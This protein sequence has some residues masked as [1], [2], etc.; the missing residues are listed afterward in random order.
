M[1]YTC[2]FPLWYLSDATD[3]G[4]QFTAQNWLVTAQAA[5]GAGAS[6]TRVDAST[7]T[8]LLQF[9]GYDISTTTI[10]YGG[11]QPGNSADL[12][13]STAVGLLAVGN[14]GLDETLYGTD[15]CPTYPTCTGNATST[16]FV[17]N[18]KYA[19]TTMAYSAAT[20]TLA[21]NPGALF[22]LHVPKTIA[23][24]TPQTRNTYWGILVPASITLS[25]NYVGTNTIIGAASPSSSW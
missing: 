7:G 13:S 3:V 18:Q 1:I 2:T 10:A 9:L 6:S 12:T 14:V 17:N 21:Y 24:S 15:M 4:S 8:E 16:I 5:D 11:L 22:A 19:S 25:G 23:T 20:S